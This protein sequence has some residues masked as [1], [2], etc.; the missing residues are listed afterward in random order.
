MVEIRHF[1]TSS[2]Q[3][4]FETWLNSLRDDV[5]EAR[6][7]ARLNRLVAGNFGDCKPVGEG[8]SE[9]R[10]DFGPGYR[11]YFGMMDRTCVLLLGGGTKRTQDSDIVR[12]IERWKDYKKRAAKP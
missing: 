6:I 9:L 8:V 7:A 5:T 10:L 1:V 3:N 11:V 4:V 12:S 2:G